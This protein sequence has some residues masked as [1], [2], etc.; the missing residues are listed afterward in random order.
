MKKIIIASILSSVITSL[1]IF[2]AG[3]IFVQKEWEGF[4]YLNLENQ[5]LWLEFYLSK[6][7]NGDLDHAVSFMKL[8]VACF[9]EEMD[10]IKVRNSED[11][12]LLTYEKYT[13]IK[14]IVKDVSC[15]D[16]S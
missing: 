12:S 14:E 15:S 7:S 5:V 4:T 3:K 1:S 8:N 10:S 11:Q 9:L 6:I 13:N 16:Q 2:A